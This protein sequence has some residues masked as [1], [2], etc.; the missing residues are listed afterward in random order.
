MK[1]SFSTLACP[2]WSLEQVLAIA[3]RCRYEGI[4]LRFLE[5]EDSLWKLPAFQGAGLRESCRRIAESGL[6]ISCLDT[7]CRFDSPAESERQRWIDEGL[8]M[9]E[10]AAAFDAPGIRVFGDRIQS[11]NTR[12]ATRAWIVDSMNVLTERIA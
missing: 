6:V 3:T 11:G 1:T 12:E 4:E 5:G 8:R 9:A 2:Q 10:L 7:S